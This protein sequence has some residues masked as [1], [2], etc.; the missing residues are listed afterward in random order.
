LEVL[1]VTKTSEPE[2]SEASVLRSLLL[3]SS[4]LGARLFRN[5]RGIERVALKSCASCNRYG[6][7]VSYGLAN[8]APDLIGWMPIVIGPEHVGKTVALFVGI[9]AKRPEGGTLSEDQ[10][11]FLAAL[12]RA[13]AVCGVARS[14]GDL[15][16]MIAPWRKCQP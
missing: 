16:T 3:V 2:R 6:R 10:R 14:A 5:A 11:R 8:G 9:E 12:E 13:G 15:E 7:T 4:H 1:T